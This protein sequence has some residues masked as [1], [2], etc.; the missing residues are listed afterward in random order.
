[1]DSIKKNPI[2]A[3][4]MLVCLLVFLAGAA[5]TFMAA[6]TVSKSDKKLQRAEQN[7]TA[8]HRGDPAP[9]EENVEASARNLTELI[10]Q[11]K[12]IR[13]DLERGASL[14]LSSDGVEVMA[15]IQQFI[16]EAGSKLENHRDIN[17]ATGEL[18]PAPI[19]AGE[20]F[21]FGF[22]AYADAATIPE[23]SKVIPLLDK[24][25][26]I[27]TAL[28]NKLL[29]AHPQSIELMERE[30]LEAKNA[31][32]KISGTFVIEPTVTARVPGAIDTLAF[33]VAF[34]GYTESLRLFLNELAKFDLPV[35]VSSV[36]VE[37]PAGSDTVDVKSAEK[38][39]SLESIFGVFGMETDAQEEEPKE[40]QKP[41]I[42][43]NLSTFTLVLE[44]IEV[45]L[46]KETKSGEGAAADAV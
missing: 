43:D 22:D 41:V 30:A 46:P 18:E 29:L 20:G 35:V 24:Q 11:L 37:R 44:F 13:V 4:V 21:A 16:S 15:S 27:L 9:S 38:N 7:L 10:D 1:M 45:V 31:T 36:E 14:K 26:L 2:F 28:L 19:T 5:L 40:A 12:G 8:A 17:S 32:D 3:A 42:V 33:R 23:D 39:D 34:K 6:G 25:R